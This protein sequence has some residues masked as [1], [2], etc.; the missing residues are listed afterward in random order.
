MKIIFV[1]IMGLL[2]TLAVYGQ[3]FTNTNMA[4]I[5]T[6]IGIGSAI[7]VVA[8]WSR[9]ESVLWAIFHGICGWLYVVYYVLTRGIQGR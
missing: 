1:T 2:L 8:S 4:A 5:N 6:G 3:G 9:N 7:A